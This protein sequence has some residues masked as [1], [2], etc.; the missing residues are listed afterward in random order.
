MMINIIKIGMDSVTG[1][2]CITVKSYVE[3]KIRIALLKIGKKE[4]LAYCS[5]K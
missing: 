4:A 2:S 3:S 5:A 1:L